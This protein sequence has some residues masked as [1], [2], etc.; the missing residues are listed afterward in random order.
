MNWFPQQPYT[1]KTSGLNVTGIFPDALRD[2]LNRVCGY[3]ESYAVPYIHFF[4]SPNGENAEK[5]S[6]MEVRQTLDNAYHIHFP[7]YGSK[8]AAVFAGSHYY[9]P[10]IN[11]LGSIV[12]VRHDSSKPFTE[13]IFYALYN[14]G[15]LVFLVILMMV[16]TGVL[17]WLLVRALAD[18]LVCFSTHGF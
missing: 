11:V 15:P 8:D 3:C 12:I 1:V 16:L 5:N 13:A 9:V 17:M 2:V 10:I 18:V 7:I 14:S 4:S 6:E